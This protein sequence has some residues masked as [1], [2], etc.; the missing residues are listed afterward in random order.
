ML[1]ELRA[2]AGCA[3]DSLNL[4]VMENGLP[5]A[6]AQTTYTQFENATESFR[7]EQHYAVLLL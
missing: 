6:S 3:L 1:D 2:G 7:A 4:P 5:P